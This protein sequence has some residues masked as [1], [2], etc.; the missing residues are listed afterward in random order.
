MFSILKPGRD[1]A[2]PSSYR[3]KDLLDTISKFFEKSLLSRILC[4]LSRSGLLRE[5]QFVF[6]TNTA[7]HY[8][9]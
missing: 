8:F 9:R 2:L 1:P 5:E 3:L 6:R 4:E 7:Q